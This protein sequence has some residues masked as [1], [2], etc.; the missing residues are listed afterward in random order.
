V[1][2]ER[3]SHQVDTQAE[4]TSIRANSNVA[5][6]PGCFSPSSRPFLEFTGLAHQAM[7]EI[8]RSSRRA[9]ERGKQVVELAQRHGWTEEP[10]EI[11]NE[12]YV[13]SN[14]VRTHIRNLY[15]KLGTHRWAEA[16]ARA[17][18]LGLLAP[19]AHRR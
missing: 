17:R 8:F 2:V 12:L 14:T 5:E 3:T 7:I 1:L 15:A 10:P 19:S 16:V 4:R 18:T 6:N 11:A 13:S 9:A